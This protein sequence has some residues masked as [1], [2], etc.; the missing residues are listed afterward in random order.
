MARLGP[1]EV[2]ETLAEGPKRT[3]HKARRAEADRPVRVV[4]CREPISDER[5]EAAARVTTPGVARLLSWGEHSEGGVWYETELPEGLTLE[6]VVARAPLPVPAALVAFDVILERLAA[7]HALGVTHGGIDA[8]TLVFTRDGPWLL[9]YGIADPRSDEK[10]SLL[11]RPPEVWRGGEPEARSD[12]YSLGILLYFACSGRYPFEA[13]PCRGHLAEPAPRLE[14]TGP[15]ELETIVGRLL[16]KFP[17]RRYESAVE[18]RRAIAELRAR[19]ERPGKKT[20][21]PGYATRGMAAARAALEEASRATRDP[22]TIRTLLD[23]SSKLKDAEQRVLEA[24]KA[25]DESAREHE[26][27]RV[28]RAIAVDRAQRAGDELGDAL[29]ALDAA[30]ARATAAESALDEAWRS[31][32]LERA[33]AHEETGRARA[34]E[35]ALASERARAKQ[36]LDALRQSAE[37]SIG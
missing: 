20:P 31:R 19:A 35:D 26:A 4:V 2:L 1:F 6:A 7:A 32:D 25:R 13:D 33:R 17:R 24:E 30:L 37:R 15:P 10:A 22:D 27:E 34:A 16:A 21:E 18:A 11:A 29:S 3:A 23:A 36:E 28:L 9:D 8:H 5:F 14:V 12:L